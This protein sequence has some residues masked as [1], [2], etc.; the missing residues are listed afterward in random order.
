[1]ALGLILT[2][3][4][5]AF[6]AFFRAF[7]RL[8]ILS[9]LLFRL[10]KRTF[11]AR[12]LLLIRLGRAV[13]TCFLLL[14]LYFFNCLRLRLRIFCCSFLITL[15]TFML[16]RFLLRR[17]RTATLLDFTF[18]LLQTSIYGTRRKVCSRILKLIFLFFK[19]ALTRMPAFDSFCVNLLTY[20]DCE[21]VIF[22][23]TT[24][25]GASQVGK[26]LANFLVRILMKRF[27]D[28]RIARWI[29]TGTLRLLFLLT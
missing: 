1:M 15:F 29:I 25:T 5:L 11:W 22:M 13:W 8:T 12:I 3:F 20:L 17:V 6:F 24:W 23:I 18:L 21:L 26:K 27:I 7:F 14:I 2:K 19:F 10:V 4:T 16:F 9:C 28:F